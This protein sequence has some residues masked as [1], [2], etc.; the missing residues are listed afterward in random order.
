MF[1]LCADGDQARNPFTGRCIASGGEPDVYMRR[2]VHFKDPFFARLLAHGTKE[3]HARKMYKQWR[4]IA[5]LTD[6]KPKKAPVP[7]HRP[8][9]MSDPKAPP[10]AKFLTPE[11]TR[12]ADAMLASGKKFYGKEKGEKK[13]KEKGEKKPKE[14]GEKKTKGK[15]EEGKKGEKKGAAVPPQKAAQH[16]PPPPRKDPEPPAHPRPKP[17]AATYAQPPPPKRAKMSSAS[18]ARCAADLIRSRNRIKALQRELGACRAAQRH[19]PAAA[20][21]AAAHPHPPPPFGMSPGMAKYRKKIQEMKAEGGTELSDEEFAR[22]QKDIQIESESELEWHGRRGQGK[23][24]CKRF[25]FLLGAGASADAGI[26]VFRTPEYA[27]DPMSSAIVAEAHRSWQ[28]HYAEAELKA[29]DTDHLLRLEGDGGAADTLVNTRINTNEKILSAV[30]RP[31]DYN[32]KPEYPLV[33]HDVLRFMQDGMH[34]KAPGGTHRAIEHVFAQGA[35]AMIVTMNIDGLEWALDLPPGNVVMPLH[36]NMFVASNSTGE[37]FALSAGRKLKASD[38]LEISMYEEEEYYLDAQSKALK[39]ELRDGACLV[40]IGTSSSVLP[41]L[42]TGEKIG[43]MI[44][45]NPDSRAVNRTRAAF[46][47]VEGGEAFR[48]V[49]D[50][51]ATY[52]PKYAEDRKK[53]RTNSGPE[54]VALAL[55][56]I[57]ET[58]EESA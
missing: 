8:K 25:V 28:K 45:I 4:Y 1:K 31:K 41:Q 22:I 21:A 43:H 14:K 57:K 42:L 52:Y 47:R 46:R 54:A 15:G 16:A 26:P 18:A 17:P 38:Y 12:R 27:R 29:D 49:A 40:A 6:T 36:G 24:R 19:T 7:D 33:L 34:D 44:V 37:T 2:L 10:S 32:E 35:G 39:K 23:A 48:T 13:P 20:V 5:R 50:F 53:R 58:M 9:K 11:E 55:A 30:R 56:Y 51:M 3:S